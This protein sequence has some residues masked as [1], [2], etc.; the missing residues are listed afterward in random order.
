[1]YRDGRRE[2]VDWLA[3]CVVGV[4]KMFSNLSYVNNRLKSRGVAFLSSYMVDSFI[5]WSF[6][7]ENL[8]EGFINNKFLWDDCFTSMTRWCEAF[9]PQ[10]LQCLLQAFRRK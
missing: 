5:V 2:N 9:V 6:E 1:M 4:M 7:S 10:V 8:K 3:R